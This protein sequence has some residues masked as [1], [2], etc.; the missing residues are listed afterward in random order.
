MTKS[1]FKNTGRNTPIKADKFSTLSVKRTNHHKSKSGYSKDSSDG[2]QLA[3]QKALMTHNPS[4]KELKRDGKGIVIGE[5][6]NPN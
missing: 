1:N 3:F 6:M 4:Q 2:S 5:F